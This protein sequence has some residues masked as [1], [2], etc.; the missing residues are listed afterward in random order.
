MIGRRGDVVEG[1]GE[2]AVRV[3]NDLPY[4]YRWVNEIKS[5]MEVSMRW[6]YCARETAQQDQGHRSSAYHLVLARER[7]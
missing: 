5:E 4:I 6:T 2:D 3:C 7:G 1:D